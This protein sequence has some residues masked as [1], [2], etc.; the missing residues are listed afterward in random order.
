M[1]LLEILGGAGIELQDQ[2][3]WHVVFLNI[4]P[5]IVLRVFEFSTI[6]GSFFFQE[7]LCKLI[8]L[9]YI[10]HVLFTMFLIQT[11]EFLSKSNSLDGEKEC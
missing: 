10:T 7:Y 11:L 5:C 2:Y 4:K 6:N 8:N 3:S 9:Y 1:S